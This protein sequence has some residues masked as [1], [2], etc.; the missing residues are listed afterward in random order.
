MLLL[1]FAVLVTI[2]CKMV[3]LVNVSYMSDG[4]HRIYRIFRCFQIFSCIQNIQKHVYCNIS[5]HNASFI[6]QIKCNKK[7]HYAVY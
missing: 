5:L 7:K 1:V 4:K 6:M 2:L 3:M